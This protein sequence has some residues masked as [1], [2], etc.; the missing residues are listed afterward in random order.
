M[1]NPFIKQLDYPLWLRAIVTTYNCLFYLVLIYFSRKYYQQRN[2]KYIAPRSPI[3]MII[4]TWL[5]CF[6]FAMLT[7]TQ[8]WNPRLYCEQHSLIW[9]LQLGT[10]ATAG[11][12]TWRCINLISNHEN[13][14]IQI[15]SLGINNN[16]NRNRCNLYRFCLTG[17]F[18]IVCKAIIIILIFI[19][20]L[21]DITL[22]PVG[23][24]D[25]EFNRTHCILNDK[26]TVSFLFS[27][28]II[29]A[30]LAF[31][32]HGIQEIYSLTF[33]LKFAAGQIICH[34]LF[35][36]PIVYT[37]NTFIG[38]IMAN[39]YYLIAFIPMH[40]IILVYPMKF[41]KNNNIY[42]TSINGCIS[43][44]DMLNNKSL[45]LQ[46]AKYLTKEFSIENLVF[47]IRVS[48]YKES[49][50]TIRYEEIYEKA[51]VIYDTFISINAQNEV[52]I[53]A[54][55]AKEIRNFFDQANHINTSQNKLI[56]IFDNARKEIVNLIDNDS[57]PRFRESMTTNI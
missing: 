56:N 36:M 44:E 2:H 25:I 27:M 41:T 5:N 51:M 12:A 48:E 34:I 31:R 13:Q 9:P 14:Q 33:E 53:S 4:F 35:Y 57:L 46:I 11:I 1:M 19:P 37:Y 22:I 52:N 23:T 38:S 42:R 16:G 50:Q 21:M 29:W 3:L 30:F 15:E 45:I 40:Y 47:I 17:R 32:I 20:I 43:I 24:D 54:N 10:G 28:C 18:I 6:N 26:V 7:L 55:T 8:V 49:S 39:L